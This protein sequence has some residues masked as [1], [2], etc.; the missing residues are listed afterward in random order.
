VLWVTKNVCLILFS[1]WRNSII[2][3]KRVHP[4][5][6]TSQKVRQRNGLATR[7]SMGDF[8]GR[9]TIGHGW[10]LLTFLS[11]VLRSVVVVAVARK[12][13][14]PEHNQDTASQ[15]QQQPMASIPCPL[16]GLN[17]TA[18]SARSRLVLACYH[19]SHAAYT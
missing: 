2:I 12:L 15:Q 13:Q 3:N 1:F 6:E 19:S 5:A 10:T 14:A 4:A 17:R 8:W 7:T 11:R 16:V 9:G 18:T